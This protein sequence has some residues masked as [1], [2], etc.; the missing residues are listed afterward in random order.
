MKSV[1]NAPICE[2]K[3]RPFPK[4][5][6]GIRTGSVY[7]MTS[8]TN[9]LLVHVNGTHPQYVGYYIHNAC[10]SDFED[11]DGTVTLSN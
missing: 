7:L 3:E 9:G 1:L 5:M 4:L 11:Y 10:V 8:K 6:E 2:K